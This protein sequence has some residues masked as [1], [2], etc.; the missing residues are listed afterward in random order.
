MLDLA[1]SWTFE[2]G[3]GDILDLD[4]SWLG[5]DHAT[6]SAHERPHLAIELVSQGFCG[7]KS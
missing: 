1:T 2:L 5:V 3:V 7:L 6:I 4:F